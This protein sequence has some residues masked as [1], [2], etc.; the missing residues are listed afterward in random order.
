MSPSPLIGGP[1]G[2]TQVDLAKLPPGVS[3]YSVVSTMSG[4]RVCTRATQYGPV[5]GSGRPKVVT[6]IS[7]DCNAAARPS[8]ST[9]AAASAAQPASHPQLQRVSTRD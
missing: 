9:V 8:S 6:R 3:G 4:G 2:S 7:G 5:A 1:D